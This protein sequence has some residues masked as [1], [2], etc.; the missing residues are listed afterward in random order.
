[1][2][3]AQFSGR[4]DIGEECSNDHL[5]RLAVQG[6]LPPFGG[7]L[8]LVTSG[9]LGVAQTSCL[10]RLHTQIPN[11]RCLYL[12]RFELVELLL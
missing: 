11:S 6:K 12:S 9:P 10:V 8:Q 4:L 5:N 3:P 1:M 2:S 7:F